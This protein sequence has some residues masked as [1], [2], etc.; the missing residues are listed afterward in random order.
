MSLATQHLSATPRQMYHPPAVPYQTFFCTLPPCDL[1]HFSFLVFSHSEAITLTETHCPSLVPSS[2][3]V[4]S[5]V[6]QHLLSSE[7]PAVP[8]CRILPCVNQRVAN[9]FLVGRVISVFVFSPKLPSAHAS[10]GCLF[11]LASRVFWGGQLH[12]V[13][14]GVGHP[15]PARYVIHRT[16]L[17]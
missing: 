11:K 5:Q 1:H 16:V 17:S 8:C 15:A 6:S 7:F 2:S 12:V 10:Y 4:Q 13:L 9:P 3:P 14:S